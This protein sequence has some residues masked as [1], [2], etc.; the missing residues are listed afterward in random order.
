MTHNQNGNSA[1]IL[2]AART[3]QGKFLGVLSAK[4]AVELGQVA[5]RGAVE[6]AEIKPED[7][8]EVILG[9]V[10]AAGVGQAAARQVWIGL[11]Y[12]ANVG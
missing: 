10:V 2:S 4:S 1:V 3:A 11:G 8:S 12:P 7:V 5:V 9:N 6:R